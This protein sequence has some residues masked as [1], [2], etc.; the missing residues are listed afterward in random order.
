MFVF[1]FCLF[2]ASEQLTADKEIPDMIV[3]SLRAA[4]VSVLKAREDEQQHEPR[5]KA[6]SQVRLGRL[7]SAN[8]QSLL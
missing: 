3:G 7:R 4:G 8:S 2:L 1:E 5:K 6:Y